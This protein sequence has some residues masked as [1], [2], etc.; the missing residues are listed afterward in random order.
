[1]VDLSDRTRYMATTVCAIPGGLAPNVVK[2]SI[3]SLTHA[4][5]EQ[6]AL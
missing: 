6:L 4:R 2:I 5:M 1:M 3:V